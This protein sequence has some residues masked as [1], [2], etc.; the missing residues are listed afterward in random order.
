MEITNS[1]L[2]KIFDI[3]FENPDFIFT[4]SSEHIKD[5]KKFVKEHAYVKSF[6]WIPEERHV[7][8]YGDLIHFETMTMRNECGYLESCSEHHNDFHCQYAIDEWSDDCDCGKRICRSYNC[9][10]ANK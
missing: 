3:A 6:G 2:T 7:F 4:I 9:P 1:D 8:K 10:I 5:V